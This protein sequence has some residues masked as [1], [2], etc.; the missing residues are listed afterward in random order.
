MYKQTRYT[1]TMRLLT[2]AWQ[3]AIRTV[4][5][6]DDVSAKIPLTRPFLLRN[7]HPAV[8]SISLSVLVGILYLF[9]AWQRIANKKTSCLCVLCV[10]AKQDQKNLVENMMRKYKK[11]MILPHEPIFTEM[12]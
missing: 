8:K 11:A 7:V 5:N 4:L 6:V 3:L 9:S 10:A 1:G 2:D 12:F